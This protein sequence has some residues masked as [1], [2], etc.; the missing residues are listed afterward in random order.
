MPAMKLYYNPV[1]SYS[2]KTLM[3]FFEK[4]V[5]F[6]PTV[7]NLMDP[8]GRADY[9]KIHPLGKM[10]YLRLDAGKRDVYESSIII[11]YIEQKYPTKGT[12]LIPADADRALQVRLR[13]RFFDFY[14]NDSMQ[15]IFFDTMR[16]TG[17][18]DPFGVEQAK[19]RLRTA[20]VMADEFLAKGPWACGEEFSLA[21]CAAAPP[22]F[23]ARNVL[24]FDEHKNLTA[25]ASRVM[26]RPSFQRVLKEAM[27]ILQQMGF[28]KK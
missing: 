21:D 6:E 17:K 24:P 11:E 27:P 4:D 7:V 19:H 28:G 12:R 10:P 15:K 1:S 5:P 9:E 14:V 8:A 22:L 23:Y 13:D 20:Y 2:Q 25:Y 26:E 16:P 3:A 18:N